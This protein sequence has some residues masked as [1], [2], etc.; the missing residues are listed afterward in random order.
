MQTA[1]PLTRSSF[2]PNGSA[3]TVNLHIQAGSAATGQGTP[4]ASTLANPLVGV[5]NDFDADL[6]NPITPDIGADERIGYFGPNP[7]H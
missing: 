1:S 2:D 5:I 3:A 7:A 6:R 4:I